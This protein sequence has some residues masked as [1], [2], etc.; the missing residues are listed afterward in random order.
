M[1]FVISVS[2]LQTNLIHLKKLIAVEFY[3]FSA[4][5]AGQC[6]V[7]MGGIVKCCSFPVCSVKIS[8]NHTSVIMSQNLTIEA[9]LMVLLT[10]AGEMCH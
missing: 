4:V 10:K 3:F 2:W 8:G 5:Q 7:E 6:E 9:V 1:G